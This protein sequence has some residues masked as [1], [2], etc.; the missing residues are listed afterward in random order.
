MLCVEAVQ[1]W[2]VRVLLTNGGI[3]SNASFARLS[4]GLGRGGGG[5]VG[6]R[7]LF[8]AQTTFQAGSALVVCL[9]WNWGGRQEMSSPLLEADSE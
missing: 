3:L 2:L 1:R 9:Y 5:T 4:L 6:D 8:Q 7:R